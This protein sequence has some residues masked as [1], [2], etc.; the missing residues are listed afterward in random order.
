VEVVAGE[1]TDRTAAQISGSRSARL[2]HV[3]LPVEPRSLA[4]AHD[5][6]LTMR[7]AERVFAAMATCWP[8]APIYTL[9][10]DPKG[11]NGTFVGR[12]IRTSWLQRLGVDQRSFR[13][14]LPLFPIAA[15]RL[16]PRAYEVL[17]TSSSAFAHGVRCA[18]DAVHVCYCHSPFRYVWHETE[19]ALRAFSPPARPAMRATL[20]T[21]RRWDRRASRRVTGY[22]ANSHL[23]RERIRRFYGR[24]APVVHPPVGVERFRP[25]EV[26]DYLLVI[27]ELVRHKRIDVALEAA[28][29][30]RRP[31]RIVGSGPDAGRLRALHGDHATFLGRVDDRELERLYRGALAV[32]VPGAEEFGIV[33]VEAQASGRPVVAYAAGGALET[34]AD[35]RTGVLVSRPTPAAFAE[36]L[37]DTDFRRFDVHELT[38]H[39]RRFSTDIFCRRIRR[40]V[41]EVVRVA[42]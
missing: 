10:Y 27:A 30:A 6:L 12:E 29:I 22:I 8:A 24:D 1:P 16:D 40:A 39:A 34:V 23:T 14:L 32:V 33:A 9:L 17:V 41:G 2:E 42:A 37:R 36:V 31:I 38:H 19:G 35:G 26:E 28:R 7:G 21:I 15:S 4:L 18:P 25:G 11:T 13:T 5:F 3:G 20:S